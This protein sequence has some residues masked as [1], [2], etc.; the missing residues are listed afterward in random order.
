MPTITFN[1]HSNTHR[2]VSSNNPN[3]YPKL[4][5]G[6]FVT[7]FENVGLVDLS[8]EFAIIAS[9]VPL[10]NAPALFVTLPWQFIPTSLE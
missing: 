10:S 2:Y 7:R 8:A 3:N 4:S 6:H 9:S 5:L 1:C